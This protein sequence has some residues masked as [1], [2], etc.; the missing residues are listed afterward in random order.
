[1]MKFQMFLSSDEEEEPMGR[2]RRR[3]ESRRN[4]KEKRTF[5]I[6]YKFFSILARTLV[7]TS[8]SAS[9]T[10]GRLPNGV[11]SVSEINQ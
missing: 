5:L 6:R 4:G 1:M 8:N 3:R 9:P 7:D 2:R 10:T 11:R